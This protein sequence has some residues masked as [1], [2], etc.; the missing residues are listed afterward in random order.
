[1][2]LGWLAGPGTPLRHR[3]V[4]NKVAFILAPRSKSECMYSIPCCMMHV[5]S[6]STDRAPALIVPLSSILGLPDGPCSN[7]P[8]FFRNRKAAIGSTQSPSTETFCCAR[9]SSISIYPFRHFSVYFSCTSR[10]GSVGRVVQPSGLLVSEG[11]GGSI[12]NIVV[13]CCHLERGD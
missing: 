5:A 7:F 2:W 9:C 11:R 1:M 12:G 10:Q 3:F 13:F 6:Q 4:P 8:L